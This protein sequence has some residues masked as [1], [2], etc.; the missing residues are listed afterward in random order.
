MTLKAVQSGRLDKPRR[1]LLYGTEGIG[2]STFAANAPAPIFIGTEDG[3]AQLDV[4]RFPEPA[5][6]Q[7]VFDAIETLRKDK[8]DYRTIVLDTL[9]WLEP[10]CWD[11]VCQQAKKP[12][13]EAFGYGKGYVAAL[14]QWRELLATLDRLRADASMDVILLAH[15]HIRT[16]RNPEGEDFDRYELKLHQKAAGLCKEWA[17]AVLYAAYETYADSRDDGRTK[18]VSTGARIIHTERRA[19]FDA[20]NRY[21]LPET[22]PLGWDDFAA[23]IE[24]PAPVD[25]LVAKVRELAE[26]LPANDAKKARAAVER[27]DGDTRK[28]VQLVDWI[29]ARIRTTNGQRKAS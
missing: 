11:H 21:T 13:I 27:A 7:D 29:Q 20:K 6:W 22:L 24:A 25:E 12:D 5:T 16:F 17:D 19:A 28:L 9:D 2:K 4:A 1:V 3:T 23:A 26:H 10:L 8:H 18:G 15:S 14:D